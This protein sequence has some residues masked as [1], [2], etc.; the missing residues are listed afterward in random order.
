MI[1]K[2]QI[3]VTFLH[4]ISTK[5]SPSSRK[6]KKKVEPEEPEKGNPDDSIYYNC[7]VT[8]SKYHVI[9]MFDDK[10]ERM[11]KVVEAI[12][13]GVVKTWKEEG[14]QGNKINTKC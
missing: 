12:A 6:R 4:T 10:A 8:L 9:A 3:D 2:D 11:E 5:F 13:H 7:T 1:D 14:N